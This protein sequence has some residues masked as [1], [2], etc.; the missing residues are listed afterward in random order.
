VP[1]LRTVFS[2]YRHTFRFYLDM[3][4]RG[5]RDADQL[6][7]LLREYGLEERCIVASVDPLFVAYLE[8]YY[9]RINTALERCDAAQ[10]W[11]YRL[12]PRRWKP[13]FNS[14]FARKVTPAH[15]EW[16]QK[17]GLL[18]QRI[19]Y[20]VTETN[21]P[22]MLRFGI[23]KAIVDYTPGPYSSALAPPTE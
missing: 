9:P 17:N 18:S 20:S 15:V 16:L 13:D 2:K 22:D 23:K 3:K 7:A 4:E 19:V 6:A 5:F 12:L 8:H 14:G 21:Y 1:T 10:V 11:V